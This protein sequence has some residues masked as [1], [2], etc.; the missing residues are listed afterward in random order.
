[1]LS[2][3]MSQ[4]EARRVRYPAY[5][6]LALWLLVPSPVLA[7]APRGEVAGAFLAGKEIGE[8]CSEGGVSIEPCSP[9]MWGWNG[10][11]GIYATDRVSLIGAVSGMYR[12]LDAE[13]RIQG[14]SPLSIPFSATSAAL[15]FAGGVRV[16][17]DR[18][19]SVRP[20]VHLLF[21]Y[22]KTDGTVEGFDGTDA[23]MTALSVSGP[24]LIPGGGVDIGVTDRVAVRLQGDLP[25]VIVEGSAI[26]SLSVSAG[27]VFSIGN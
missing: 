17:R 4:W 10:S 22:S 9:W 11:F 5:G 2:R 12:S 6:A 20:F 26:S 16:H 3:T 13:L 14:P 27:L 18:S 19:M 7:Q 25:T 24:T 15:T 1:M 23:V 21:G 8:N